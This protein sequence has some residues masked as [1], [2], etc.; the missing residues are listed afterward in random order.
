MSSWGISEPKAARNYL[1]ESG[2]SPR[3]VAIVSVWQ[4]ASFLYGL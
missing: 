1:I 2:V 3:Q 4:G